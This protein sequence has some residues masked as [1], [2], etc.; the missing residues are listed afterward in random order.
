MSTQANTAVYSLPSDYMGHLTIICDYKK[1][2][3]VGA[4]EFDELE[5]TNDTENNS[6]QQLETSEGQ[7]TPGFPEYYIDRGLYIELF[8]KPDDVYTL[9]LKYYALP[10]SFTS[11]TDEDYMSRFHFESIIFG[12]SLRGAIFLD[13]TEKINIF[14][15]AYDRSLSEIVA[16]EKDKKQKDTHVRVKSWRDY[17]VES[18]RRMHRVKAS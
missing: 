15:A 6:P 5:K 1:L 8:P 9:T 3:R 2:M 12:T 4:R 14:K 11:D 7:V 16:R 13:D 10:A 17:E 18:F